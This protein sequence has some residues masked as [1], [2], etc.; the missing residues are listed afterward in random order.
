MRTSV[1]NYAQEKNS[2]LQVTA[3]PRHGA[4]SKRRRKL[5]SLK[6]SL[7][8]PAQF[9]KLYGGSFQ[10]NLQ[11]KKNVVYLQCQTF[12]TRVFSE[13]FSEKIYF[14]VKCGLLILNWLI[15][16]DDPT[17]SGILVLNSNFKLI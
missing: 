5:F 8:S 10:K 7:V 13:N 14:P 12:L 3:T 11:V 6:K 17:P 9:I 16:F 1:K 2:I 15:V 4:I